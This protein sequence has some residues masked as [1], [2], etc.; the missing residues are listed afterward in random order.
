M[1][2]R[3]IALAERE[4]LILELTT[5]VMQLAIRQLGVWRTDGFMP[6]ISVNISAKDA[7]D[8]DFP[9]R[10]MA[11]CAADHVPQEQIC[12]EITESAA[13]SKPALMLEVLTRLRLRGFRLAIDD[14]GTGYSSL[15]QLHRLPVSVLTLG[16]S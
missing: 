7:V 3:F 6:R 5:R 16:H 11:M 2:D 4:D 13:M 8:P 12:L 9:D 14:F 15:L 1:P 10:L